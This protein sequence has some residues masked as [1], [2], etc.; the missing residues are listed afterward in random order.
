MLYREM[1]AVCDQ[2]H[3]KHAK[4]HCVGRTWNF[5]MLHLVV[6]K[7]ATRFSRV[8]A[9]L[10]EDPQRYSVVRL[11]V[12]PVRKNTVFRDHTVWYKIRKESLVSFFREKD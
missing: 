5:K 9:E 1:I 3:T 11:Q 2:I 6:H 8:N 10:M 4:T 7:V 12:T